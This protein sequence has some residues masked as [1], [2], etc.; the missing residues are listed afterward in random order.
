MSDSYRYRA[1][2]QSSGKTLHGTLEAASRAQV[3]AKLKAQG[4]VPLKVAEVSKTG[5]QQDIDI[6]WLRKPVS[7]S[8]LATMTRQ[9]SGMINAGVPLLRS[10]TIIAGQTQQKTLRQALDQVQRDIETGGSFS[11]ALQQQPDVF[12][13]LMVS[14]VRVG[15][16]GGFLGTSLKSLADTYQRDSELRNKIKAAT[17]Y[18]LV[19]LVIAVL[20]MVAMVWFV[21]PVFEGMFS[22]LG[23]TLPGPTQFLVNLSANMTWLAPLLLVLAIAIG[24]Y[25]RL[26]KN[27]PGVRAVVDP[28]QLKLPVFGSL[29]RRIQVTRFS[30]NLS[31][32]LS[33]GVPLT[34][35]LAVTAESSGNAVIQR[36]VLDALESVREGGSLSAPLARATVF[37]PTLAHM[38]AVGEE[39]GSLPEMLASIAETTENEV[40]T[41]ADQL[42][43][44]LEP[45]LLVV[46][47]ALVGAMVIALYLPILTL[48]GEIAG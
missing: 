17:T 41:E 38:V 10:I 9:L 44:T 43:S 47:G 48:Y 5:L 37:P 33:S 31:M 40:N 36:A 25:W 7:L 13:P 27:R 46:V 22:G 45:L 35:A 8:D 1:L 18:P 24:V 12:P 32:L 21:V 2:D 39:S 29:I 3:A 20:G 11:Q 19:V 34:Q 23:T 28:I 42:A 4:L 15:E 30:R 14:V 16:T 26:N 6:P